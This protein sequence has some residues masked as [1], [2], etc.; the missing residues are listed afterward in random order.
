MG[1]SSYWRIPGRGKAL[2][3]G[4]R[5]SFVAALELPRIFTE[6]DIGFLRGLGVGSDDFRSAC[7]EIIEAINKHGVIDVYAEY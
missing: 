1:A 7:G 4:G 5:S 6:A 2:D 3:V